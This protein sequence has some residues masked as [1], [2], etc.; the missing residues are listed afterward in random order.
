MVG[1]KQGGPLSG[2]YINEICNNIEKL[3]TSGACVVVVA[4]KI[5]LYADVM[6]SPRYS[7]ETTKT[8][9]CFKVILYRQRL[10]SKP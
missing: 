10:I 9:K 5:L 2:L 7:R 1:V 3:P 6:L 8:S 4:L